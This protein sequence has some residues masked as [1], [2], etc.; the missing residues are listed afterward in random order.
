MDL[1]LGLNSKYIPQTRHVYL[2][3]LGVFIL[4]IPR[5]RQ[6]LKQARLLPR[7]PFEKNLADAIEKV[8]AAIKAE[9][10]EDSSDGQD[11]LK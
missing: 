2:F 5:I 8:R 1:H 7:I 9:P 6:E 3:D 10:A 4:Y 11:R